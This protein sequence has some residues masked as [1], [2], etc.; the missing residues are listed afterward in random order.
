MNENYKTVK[1]SFREIVVGSSQ[2]FSEATK[3]ML[4]S[5]EWEDELE[6]LEPSD[7]M[8]VCFSKE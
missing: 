2:W 5:M 8:V 3:I 6:E 4:T 1:P 7:D